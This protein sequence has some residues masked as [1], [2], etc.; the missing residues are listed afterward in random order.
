MRMAFLFQ[1]PHFYS[2]ILHATAAFHQTSNDT[3]KPIKE[4][5]FKRKLK[6]ISFV[7]VTE[8][9]LRWF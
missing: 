4:N 6:T 5:V 1:L 3:P 7:W 2:H 9:I 8:D